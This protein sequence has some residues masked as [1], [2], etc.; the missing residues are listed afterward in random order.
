METITL[1]GRRRR[2]AFILISV[3]CC[4]LLHALNGSAARADGTLV[5]VRVVPERVT[6]RGARAAQRFVVLGA[7]ADG[8]ER[9]VTGQSHFSI[10]GPRFASLDQAGRV[11]AQADGE[12][13][14]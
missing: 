9:D 11:V 7:F 1:A 5:S 8:L 4:C 3:V 14:L 2:G 12:M 10:S 13:D 6:L